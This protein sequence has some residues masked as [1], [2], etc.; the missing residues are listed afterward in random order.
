[1]DVSRGLGLVVLLAATSGACRGHAK[2]A[3]PPPAAVPPATAQPGATNEIDQDLVADILEHHRFHHQGGLLT[4]IAMSLDALGLPEEQQ[5]RVERI[6][7]D[8]L[9]KLQPAIAAERNLVSLLASG[10]GA[11]RLDTDGLHAALR[12]VANTT[13]AARQAAIAD[14]NRLHSVLA[15]AERSALIDRLEAHWALWQEAN[16]G[17]EAQLTIIGHELRLTPEQ[18]ARARASMAANPGALLADGRVVAQLREL[19]AAFRADAFDASTLAAASAADGDMATAGAQQLVRVCVA[20]NP[21]LDDE[22]RHLL[23][24]ILQSHLAH[25]QTQG[26]QP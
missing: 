9:G 23:V 14:L 15:P 24:D 5:L 19:A 1:M 12:Q 11:S 2:N 25:D 6:Q 8:L 17:D 13:T 22:Q 18:L 20:V 3:P 16:A 7:T 26:V 10:L 21:V 4:L